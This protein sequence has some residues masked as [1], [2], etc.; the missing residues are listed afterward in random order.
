MIEAGGGSRGR[1]MAALCWHTTPQP[2]R[3]APGPTRM[4]HLPTVTQKTKK[5]V[6]GQPATFCTLNMVSGQFCGRGGEGRGGGLPRQAL[7]AAASIQAVPPRCPP[8]PCTL[9]FASGRTSSVR[10][11]NTRM[12]AFQKPRKEGSGGSNAADCAPNTCSPM[13]ANTKMKSTCGRWVGWVWSGSVARVR[14]VHA[15][16]GPAGQGSRR[17][18]LHSVTAA[19]A[20]QP[21]HQPGHPP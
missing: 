1:C 18:A 6:E 7:T 10:T 16:R 14:W 15:A 19:D 9:F 2:A 3:P 12:K 8:Q 11:W 5:R 4:I 20:A 17:E 21:P 13:S